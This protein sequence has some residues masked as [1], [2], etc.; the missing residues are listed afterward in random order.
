MSVRI[1]AAFTPTHDTAGLSGF[2][3]ID[4][5][6]PP[7]TP[8]TAP[9][10]GTITRHSG[11]DPALPPPLGQGGPWGLSIYFV[12]KSKKV[13]YLTHLAQ[14][15]R[16][17]AYRGGDVIGIIGDYPGNAPGADHVHEG[18][19]QG[20]SAEAHYAS[21]VFPARCYLAA[22]TKP[23]IWHPSHPAW[24]WLNAFIKRGHWTHP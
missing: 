18:L 4:L 13:Y 11:H 8:I 6:A 16:L 14:V 7:G 20:D 17:G 12:G 15:A 2:P 3:A 22:V 10:A 19:H 5:F 21:T 24:V 9:E 23:K 1:L